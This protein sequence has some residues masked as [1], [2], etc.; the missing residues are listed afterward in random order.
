MS[1]ERGFTADVIVI[2]GGFFGCEAA[3][4]LRR[5]GLERVRLVEREP[6]LLRRASFVNQARV[7]GGYHY[8]RALATAVRSNRNLAAFTAEY[9]EAVEARFETYYA[10]ARGSRV[11][12]DQ[13]ETFCE[14]IGAFWRPAGQE[15]AQLFEPGTVE[16]VVQV[17][18]PAFDARRLAARLGRAMAAAGVE[19]VL[20]R[21]ATVVAQDEAGV[22]VSVGG[23]PERARYVLNCA[24]AGLDAVGVELKSRLKRELA[25]LALIA[26]PPQLQ[27][28]AVTVMDGPFFSTMPFPPTRLHTLSHVRYTPHEAVDSDHPTPVKSHATA[29][30]RDAQ[31]Y[32]PCLAHARIERSLFEVKAVLARNEDDDGRPILVERSAAGRVLS[33]LGSKIDNIYELRDFLRSQEWN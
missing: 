16:R 18:E 15:V 4:E 3:L 13:F 31:R 11:S 23:R 6:G 12:A 26:P 21:P 20:E 7:H 28:R 22:D 9:G 19:V 1:P 10:I 30:L 33:V 25:E 14:A 2:G 32:L 29:M 5:L 27:G 17:R 8:P 24:Y